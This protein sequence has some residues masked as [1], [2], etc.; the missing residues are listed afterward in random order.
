MPWYTNPTFLGLAAGALGAYGASQNNR[1]SS[2]ESSGSREPWGPA[3]QD[4]LDILGLGREVFE[5]QRDFRPPPLLRSG[6]GESRSALRELA[7]EAQR[8]AMESDFVPRA[9]EMALGLAGGNPLINR[10]WELA[11]AFRPPSQASAMAYNSPLQALLAN[12]TAGQ[13]EL[14]SPPFAAMPRP[15]FPGRPF[16]PPMASPGVLSP[17]DTP[18]GR[19]AALEKPPTSFSPPPVID[20]YTPTPTR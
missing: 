4:L 12:L 16:S 10:T 20:T 9:Q 19:L 7:Q 14:G 15:M 3:R 1:G 5:H 11:A 8:R 2:S 17:I 13:T 6:G 18:L